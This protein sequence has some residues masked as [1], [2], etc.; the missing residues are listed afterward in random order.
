MLGLRDGRIGIVENGHEVPLDY[1]Q[2]PHYGCCNAGALNPRIA[3]NMIAFFARR[4]ERW[5][6]VEIEAFEQGR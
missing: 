1:D 3:R 6:H 4:G 5:Y 2:V